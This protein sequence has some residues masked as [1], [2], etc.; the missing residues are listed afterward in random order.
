[1]PVLLVE[2]NSAS[3]TDI[4]QERRTI[5]KVTVKRFVTKLSWYPVEPTQ[6]ITTTGMELGTTTTPFGKPVPTV[7]GGNPW[8]GTVIAG[9]VLNMIGSLQETGTVTVTYDDITYK[10]T[11]TI[12]NPSG[13]VVL[14]F[15][16]VLDNILGFTSPVTFVS[17]VAQTSSRVGYAMGPDYIMVCSNRLSSLQS[18]SAGRT[19]DSGNLLFTVPINTSIGGTLAFNKETIGCDLKICDKGDNSGI[20]LD[21]IDITLINPWTRTVFNNNGAAVMLELDCQFVN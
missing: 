21:Q 15:G 12:F 9:M 13:N 2:G 5:R 17:T 16:T 19:A 14:N 20:T 10:Y 3:F 18:F 11:I 4:Y 7:A 8:T 1:M 6:T